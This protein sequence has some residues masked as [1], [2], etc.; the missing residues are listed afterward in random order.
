[1][2]LIEHVGWH[3]TSGASMFRPAR[4]NPTASI[5]QNVDARPMRCDRGAE[6]DDL[7]GANDF[8]L[9]HLSS[10][11]RRQIAESYGL[12]QWP[13]PRTARR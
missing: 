7:P 8:S 5:S 1:M 6:C 10:P 13:W 11:Y 3:I 2:R 12:H 9:K 4:M